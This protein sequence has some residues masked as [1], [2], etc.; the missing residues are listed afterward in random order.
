[1][2]SRLLPLFKNNSSLQYRLQQISTRFG[3]RVVKDDDAYIIVYKAIMA[4]SSWRNNNNSHNT[5]KIRFFKDFFITLWDL[6]DE[7]RKI[8]KCGWNL[9]QHVYV[10]SEHYNNS[11]TCLCNCK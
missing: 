1:M 10:T 11:R 5:L 4:S 7:N 3:Y 6:Y 9:E 8:N 2:K